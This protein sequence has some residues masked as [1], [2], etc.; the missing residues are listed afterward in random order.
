MYVLVFED[1]GIVWGVVVGIGVS[2]GEIFNQGLGF[3]DQEGSFFGGRIVVWY[4]WDL[5]KGELSLGLVFCCVCWFCEFLVDG[6]MFG[7]GDVVL[8][9]QR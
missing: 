9:L 5:G 8:G 7:D 4:V 3:L 2:L 1:Y 6:V